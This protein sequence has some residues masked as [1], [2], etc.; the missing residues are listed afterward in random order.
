MGSLPHEAK[1]SVSP[2]PE[3]A[4]SHDSL[5][6]AALKMKQ[7][8][9]RRVLPWVW[10][11]ALL[12]VLPNVVGTAVPRFSP[13]QF[14]IVV[15]AVGLVLLPCLLPIP[16]RKMMLLLL[17]LVALVPAVTFYQAM[18]HSA[19]KEWSFIVLMETNSQETAQFLPPIIMAAILV[20]LLLWVYWLVVTRMI[21][22]GFTLVWRGRVV[23]I[24]LGLLLPA[25]DLATFGP[26][27][28]WTAIGGRLQE[29]YPFGTVAAGW[30]AM[31]LR[32]KLGQRSHT[33]KDFAVE[34]AR[35][36]PPGQREIHVLVVGETARASS[37]Q[38]DGYPRETTPL[39]SANPDVI[40][41][42]D[43]SAAAPC[44]LLSVP[45][46]LTPASASQVAQAMSMPSCM[47]VFK[48]AGYR[49]HWLSTQRKHGPYDTTVSVFSN[50]AD[51]AAFLSGKLDTA[52]RGRY[53]ATF[54]G[55]LLPHL[56]ESLAKNEP[57]VLLVLHT[58]GSHMPYHRRYPAKFAHFSVNTAVCETVTSMG[59]PTP[60]Q[61][62]NME[63]AY[64]NSVRYTDYVLSQ[65][66]RL[67]EE[68]K[69]ISTMTY[70][71]DHGENPG[72]TESMPY[73]HGDMT[74]DVLH[75]PM[76]VWASHQFR[77]KYPAQ[78]AALRSHITTPVSAT[79]TFHL[80]LDLAGLHTDL[81]KRD[82]SPA[83]S[84]FKSGPRLVA[85]SLTW[86]QDYDASFSPK[87]KPARL[88]TAAR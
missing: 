1:A 10:L 7:D 51:D 46:L 17:P 13:A 34:P 28:G 57:R 76:M 8:E 36:L 77:E 15:H 66:I 20:P 49:V 54:D 88:Q 19:P 47:G 69:A 80:L 78:V 16:V 79:S 82:L 59:K 27:F 30:N 6:R 63:N 64:D 61:M 55:D 14:I 85:G 81:L 72:K 2:Y 53:E 84:D 26:Q 41:F 40:S 75:V 68:Q 52:E 58:M 39:L 48:K 56:K 37:F 65:V 33:S 44:T 3:A 86:T 31:A 35:A 87:A 4:G 5:S 22:K 38:I 74:Q 11:A 50:D 18:T 67:L 24:L 71:S 70:V 9:E 23:V 60:E 45:L 42:Q 29:M 21:P 83:N 43:V 62:V 32:S 25:R 12:L 73:A